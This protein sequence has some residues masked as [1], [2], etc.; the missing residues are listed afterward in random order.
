[1]HSRQPV[2]TTACKGEITEPLNND[3]QNFFGSP[4]CLSTAFAV[5]RDLILLST[6]K[7]NSVIGLRQIS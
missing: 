3:T 4:A 7:F 2:R 5:C 1:M 6:T